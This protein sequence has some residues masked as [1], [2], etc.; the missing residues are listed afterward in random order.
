MTDPFE[1]QVREAMTQAAPR[2]LSKLLGARERE[3]YDGGWADAINVLAPRVVAAI[4]S[5]R[6][7][8]LED[9]APAPRAFALKQFDNAALAA[10]RGTP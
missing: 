9:F 8:S 10:L 1:A 7:A 6:P 4:R 2:A 3:M 5:G